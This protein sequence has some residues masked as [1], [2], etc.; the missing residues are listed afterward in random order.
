MSA[1]RPKR[2]IPSAV[3][4]P[5]AVHVEASQAINKSEAEIILTDFISVSEAIAGS[6]PSSLDSSQI[7]F[8]NT[9]LSSGSGSSA[10]LSQLKR[11]QRDLRG[12]PPL[13]SEV[14]GSTSGT[15]AAA[16]ITNKK[17]KFDDDGADVSEEPKNKKIKFD[18][19]EVDVSADVEMTDP[20]ATEVASDN[21]SDE[22]K[23]EEEEEEQ[24]KS[25]KESKKSKK[26]KHDKKEKKEKKHKKDKKEKKDKKKESKD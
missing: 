12:L 13:L 21:E 9:G 4:T 16:E 5:T 3:N 8:S 11:V 10:I 6:L 22:K 15:I 7:T 17:I 19:S 25:H 23:E 24:D 14:V 26:E 2:S 20:V 18:D 1:Y